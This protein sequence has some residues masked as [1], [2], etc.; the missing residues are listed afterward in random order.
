MSTTSDSNEL[1]IAL[2]V[3]FRN[4]GLLRQSLVHRSYL[5]ENPQY[6]LGCNERLEFLGDAF[7]GLVVAD[8][9]FRRYPE[10]DEGY[11]T[12]LRAAIVRRESL[13]QIG[14]QIDLGRFLYLGRGESD[15][16]GVDRDSNLAGAVEALVAAVFVDRG[17]ECA[18]ALTR[19]LVG[20]QLEL[21]LSKGPLRDIKTQLQEFAQSYGMGLPEYCVIATDG[22]GHAPE[23][24]VQV[25]VRGEIVGHGRGRR[26]TDAEREAAREALNCMSVRTYQMET[27]RQSS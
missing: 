23:F 18:W 26:K 6:T 14:R 7:I 17:F 12:E 19:R 16:G 22:S 27:D 1:E 15:A 24:I 11:L 3:S 21:V 13:A 4:L 25:M 9:L 20:P 8:D 5:N 2:G 10:S